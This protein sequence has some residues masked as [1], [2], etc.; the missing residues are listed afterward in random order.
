[1]I[2]LVGLKPF[3]SSREDDL[4]NPVPNVTHSIAPPFASSLR[5]C[6][7]A[8]SEWKHAERDHGE[9]GDG[10]LAQPTVTQV[11]PSTTLA[12]HAEG[13]DEAEADGWLAS[14]AVTGLRGGLPGAMPE[15]LME[16]NG[17]VISPYLPRPWPSLAVHGLR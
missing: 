10:L 6:V 12:E 11:T 17:C 14:P 2:R 15:A 13:G 9:R 1:M 7:R 4:L 8:T 16:R 3:E 5:K